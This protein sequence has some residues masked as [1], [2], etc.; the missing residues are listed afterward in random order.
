MTRMSLTSLKTCCRKLGL[1]RCPT[2]QEQL[3]VTE[4]LKGVEGGGRGSAAVLTAAG[5]HEVG[6]KRISRETRILQEDV[7]TEV[8]T[9]HLLEGSWEE[10]ERWEPLER[11]W[12]AWYMTRDEENLSDLEGA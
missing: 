9:G 2:A 12:I 1:A 7:E 3:V 8:E 5:S 6:N 4:P 10:V 11:S